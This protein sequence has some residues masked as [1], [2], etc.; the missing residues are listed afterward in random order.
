MDKYMY[1]ALF[2]S[3]DDGGYTVSFPDLKGC[4]TEGDDLNE[5]LKMA[6]DALELFLWNMEDE[7]EEIPESTPPEKIEAKTGS[8][9]VPIE[10]DMLLIRAKMDNKTVNTTVTMPKWLKYQAEKSKINFSQV[11]QEALKEKLNI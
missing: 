10:A 7:N 4:I 6:K 8:F 5:A 9:V 11:L 3:Y 1:P 2:E